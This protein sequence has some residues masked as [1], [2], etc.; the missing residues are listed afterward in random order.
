MTRTLRLFQ[1]MQSL[2]RHAAPVT[3]QTL[4]DDTGV[5]L[6]TLYRDIGSLRGLGA[7][8]DGTA[9][10]GYALT[11]D[12]ALPPL[13]FDDE[14]IEALVLGLRQVQAIADP[15]LADAAGNALGKLQARLP[16]A[17]AHR[18]KHAVL[19]VSKSQRPSA[20]RI[21]VRALR[22]AAWD[23]WTISIDYVDKT[24]AATARRVDPL[25]VVFFQETHCL[26]AWCHL[27]QDFRAF[28]LDRMQQMTVTGQSFRPRRV[29]MLRAAIAAL[30]E[31]AASRDMQTDG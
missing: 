23:E 29:P 11:E 8:I 30:T 3:A 1:L 27:R 7:V 10:Y 22:K 15:D 21:N 14:E 18:L 2:R 5:S 4:A 13:M 9:G 31:Q 19:A 26:I 25:C 24:G 16:S 17:Q 12:A 28:R 6:R 20:P